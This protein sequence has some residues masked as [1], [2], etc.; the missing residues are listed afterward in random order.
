MDLMH[1]VSFLPT[2]T[3]TSAFSQEYCLANNP[4]KNF[5]VLPSSSLPTQKYSIR[6]K[7]PS[8]QT[9]SKF[10]SASTAMDALGI[11][12]HFF[13]RID[14]HALIGSKD[15]DLIQQAGFK[16]IRFDLLWGLVEKQKNIFDF[17][18]YDA[19]LQDLK[20]RGITPMI[21]LELGN[22]LYAKDSTIEPSEVRKA[23][24]RYAK[25]AISRY[26]GQGLIFE[27]TNEPNHKIFWKPKPNVQDYMQLVL[28]LV[29][30]LRKLDPSA[31]FVAPST[32]GAPKAFLNSCFK[33]GL[34]TLVDG[35]TVHPYQAFYK[36]P[37]INRAPENVEKEYQRTYSLIQKFAPSGKEIPILLGEWGYSSGP[38]EVDEETQAN[39]LVR[40]AMWSIMHRV[41]VNIWY[42]WKGDS[43]GSLEIPDKEHNF[44]IVHLS[45]EPK[46]AY[47]AMFELNQELNGMQFIRRKPSEA[48]DYILEFGNSTGK[49]TLVCWTLD[50]SH[51]MNLNGQTLKLT[52]KPIYH[53][54]GKQN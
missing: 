21:I 54:I 53:H 14:G 34:L 35:V 9:L 48:K 40:Q 3:I 44:E 37:P 4:V 28:G 47:R 52:G 43:L 20:Q 17:A 13:S 23:F 45:L 39:Y 51:T 41:P 10:N 33:L 25:A 26:K 27:L 1:P 6:Y 7:Y 16:K 29:P 32:A 15:L 38:G 12:V 24:A 49:Q 18:P 22:P 36:K 46:P 19:V 8:D 2:Q 30:T 31:I 11:N 5:P 50:T 42:D